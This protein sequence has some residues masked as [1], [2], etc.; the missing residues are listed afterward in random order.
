MAG[1]W[2]VFMTYLHVLFNLL[3]MR[4]ESIIVDTDKKKIIQIAPQ[5]GREDD[6]PTACCLC[7]A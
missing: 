6:A 1:S 7:N 5:Q 3:K 4:M 2:H